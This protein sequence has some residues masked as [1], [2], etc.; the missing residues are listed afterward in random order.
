[1]K[2]SIERVHGTETWI[3]RTERAGVT[4]REGEVACRFG[5]R[6]VFAEPIDA[7]SFVEGFFAAFGVEVEW[8][9]G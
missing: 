4:M 3:G 9:E 2:I 6:S 8:V 7:A 5:D 1:M